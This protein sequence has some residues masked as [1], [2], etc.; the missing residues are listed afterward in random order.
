M[1]QGKLVVSSDSVL[2]TLGSEVVVSIDSDLAKARWT[3]KAAN[4][5]TTARPFIWGNAV[6]L[7]D[8]GTLSAFRLADGSK[9]WTHDFPNVVRGIGSEGEILYIGTRQGTVY[10]YSPGAALMNLN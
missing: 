6:L 8:R 4:E 2:V 9:L 5:W 3:E 10:A 1:P 7:A